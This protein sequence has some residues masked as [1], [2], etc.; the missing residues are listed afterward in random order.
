MN[1]NNKDVFIKN[2][3]ITQCG[4]QE[5]DGRQFDSLFFDARTRTVFSKSLYMRKHTTVFTSTSKQSDTIYTIAG[6][7]PTDIGRIFLLLE[8]INGQNMIMVVNHKTKR[9]IPANSKQD[10]INVMGYK[11]RGAAKKLMTILEENHVVIEVTHKT[12]NETTGKEDRYKRYYVSPIYTMPYKGLNLDTYLLFKE[13]ID[14]LLDPA[15][16]RELEK[17]T[18]KDLHGEEFKQVATKPVAN[19][20]ETSLIS[21]LDNVDKQAVFD[22]YILHGETPKTYQKI[23]K[24]MIAAPV[25][26]DN[27]TYFA[28]NQTE[29]YKTTKPAG[30]DIIGYNAWFIDIDAGRDSA[31]KY[32]PLEEV[33]RRKE[34]MLNVINALLVPTAIVDTRNGYHIY[35][36]CSGDVSDEN[37][38]VLE[39]KLFDLAKIAD[40]AAT[41]KSRLLRLPNSKWVKKENGLAPYD[42]TILSANRINYTTETFKK[43]LDVAQEDVHGAVEDYLSTYPMIKVSKAQ[44]ATSAASTENQSARVQAIISLSVN[45]FDPVKEEGCVFDINEYLHQFNLA[46]FLQIENPSSFKCILHDDH[47]PSA[48][49]YQNGTGYRYMC[50][51]SGCEGNNEGKGLDIIGVVMTLAKCTYAQAVNY[52]CIIWGISQQATA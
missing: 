49:I 35:Y 2:T 33:S 45:T 25:T 11:S 12:K 47:S 10:I 34:K 5:G 6:H 52:L 44:T 26:T 40:P 42:V 24:G 16:V 41:E 15:T 17:I 27:D 9:A 50:G 36:A 37:W 1:N 30:A 21:I 28:V 32:F 22:E 43:Q 48:T 3:Q 38:K 51:S 7:N 4:E 39:D 46:E 14:D 31:G 29:G 19:Q 23:G 13:Q 18:Y 20:N 8:N